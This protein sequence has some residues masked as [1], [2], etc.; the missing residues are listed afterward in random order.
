LFTVKPFY[1]GWSESVQQI[2]D[3]VRRQARVERENRGTAAV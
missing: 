2:G 1:C 3:P